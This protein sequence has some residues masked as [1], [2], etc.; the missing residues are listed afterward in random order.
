MYRRPPK[1][2][3]FPLVVEE[4]GDEGGRALD[5]GERGGWASWGSERMRRVREV[6]AGGRKEEGPKFD[7]G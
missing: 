4:G 6:E 2:P 5:L 3:F 1:Q 7:K